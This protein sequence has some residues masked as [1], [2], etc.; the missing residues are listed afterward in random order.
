MKV[1][2]SKYLEPINEDK[3]PPIGDWNW[4][5]KGNPNTLVNGTKTWTNASTFA[6]EKDT[7]SDSD[8]TKEG[9]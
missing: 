4:K 9:D 3:L 1:F 2:A 7:M 8:M 5:P 6:T